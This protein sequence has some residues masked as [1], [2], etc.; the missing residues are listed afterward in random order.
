MNNQVLML[1]NLE[2]QF[3][4]R[5]VE[6]AKKLPTFLHVLG[7]IRI[8]KVRIRQVDG[9]CRAYYDRKRRTICI[10]QRCPR[11]YKLISIV[12]EYSHALIRTTVDPEPGVTGKQEFID[13]CIEDETVAIVTELKCVKDLIK[14]GVY[15]DDKELEWLN[16]YQKGGRRAIRK[17][18]ANTITSTTGEDYITYYGAWYDEMIPTHLRLP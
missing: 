2:R 1:H 9:P 8:N 11:N 12:H 17:K 16:V 4:K 7:E 15:I 10:G 5:F 3:G 14:A 18:L 6:T 13:S